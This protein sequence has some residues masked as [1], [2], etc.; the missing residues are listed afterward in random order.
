MTSSSPTIS[1]AGKVSSST[2]EVVAVESSLRNVVS[3]ALRWK[4]TVRSSGVSI[5]SSRMTCGSES[6]SMSWP[7]STEEPFGSAIAMLRSNEYFTSEEVSSLPLENVSPSFSVQV[8]VF[9]SSYSHDSA[10]SPTGSL[11]PAGIAI[12]RWKIAYCMFHEPK[13]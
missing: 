8:I 9:G 4:T 7:S 11:S 13:S 3:A 10:A 6:G 1:S 2:I 5:A 12:S